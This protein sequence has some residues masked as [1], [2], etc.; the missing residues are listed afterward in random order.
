MTTKEKKAQ[1]RREANEK[2]GKQTRSY[3][4]KQDNKWGGP[5][6]KRQKYPKTKDQL[7]ERYDKD[8]ATISEQ[9]AKITE[10]EQQLSRAKGEQIV[11]QASQQLGIDTPAMVE[12][13]ATDWKAQALKWEKRFHAMAKI[14]QELKVASCSSTDSADSNPNA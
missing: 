10:L 4:W 1:Q 13:E 11:S 14:A 6:T 7:K 5:P 9:Q 8:Q 12:E 3:K 2:R